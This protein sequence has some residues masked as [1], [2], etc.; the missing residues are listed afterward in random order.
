[1]YSFIIDVLDITIL[2]GNFTKKKIVPKVKYNMADE[3]QTD[4]EWKFTFSN[5]GTCVMIFKINRR[6]LAIITVLAKEFEIFNKS[7]N[8]V[9]YSLQ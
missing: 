8:I 1:M 4:N 7:I 3:K 9:E 5:E 6:S 2:V